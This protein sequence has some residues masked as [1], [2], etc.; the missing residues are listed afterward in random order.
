MS[1]E[2]EH[3]FINS[4]LYV[5]KQGVEFTCEF[6][7]LNKSMEGAPALLTFK[8]PA[9]TIVKNLSSTSNDDEHKSNNDILIDTFLLDTIQLNGSSKSPLQINETYSCCLQT[10]T[11]N[12]LSSSFYTKCAY[13][14][15]L[16]D[17]DAEKHAALVYNNWHHTTA[18][19]E[20]FWLAI[21]N[22][23]MPVSS[24]LLLLSLCLLCMMILTYK[25]QI[26][27]YVNVFNDKTI[28]MTSSHLSNQGRE[29]NNEG[30]GEGEPSSI[31][32][33]AASTTSS[34]NTSSN[35]EVFTISAATKQTEAALYSKYNLNNG[36]MDL[37]T[38]HDLTTCDEERPPC[39]N[40]LVLAK[41]VNEANEIEA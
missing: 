12:P 16:S 5:V 39:Y 38:L 34:I 22:S 23:R 30:G 18:S 20:S 15:V 37:N 9:F 10:A 2:L 17:Q 19:I 24:M 41:Q 35:E 26:V 7:I 21:N 33:E 29:D 40:T 13:L 8:S 1:R 4:N 11:M 31:S 28:T 32:T 14:L 3:E 6:K 27:K 36:G 25:I